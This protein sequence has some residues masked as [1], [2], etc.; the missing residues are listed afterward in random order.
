VQDANR[1]MEFD[2]AQTAEPSYYDVSF[3][4][5]PVWKWEVV[6][7]FFLGGI[8]AG[9]YVLARMAERFGGDTYRDVTRTGTHV[10]LAT[11]LPCAPLLI[12][13]LG[14]PKRF[15]HMLRIFKPTSPMNLGT[16]TMTSFVGMVMAN[17]L[18]EWAKD[19][20]LARR[21]PV[22]TVIDETVML[23]IDAAGVPLGIMLAG[24]T[25]VLLSCTANPLWAQ[26]PWIGPLFSASA[27]STGAAAINL[28]HAISD[29]EIDTPSSRALDKVDTTAHVIEA[30]A[31][32]GFLRHAG[33]QARPLRHGGLKKHMAI[34]GCAIVAS[35][36]LKRLPLD[37]EAKRAAS[38]GAAVC[39]L[40]TGFLLRWSF[41]YGGHEAARDPRAAR[42]SS[43]APANRTSGRGR[44]FPH[45]PPR[46]RQVEPQTA[47]GLR[48]SSPA[49]PRT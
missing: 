44:K 15:H 28:L 16:W 35:E 5:P 31:L 42:S 30:V 27:I 2:A 45:P 17:S 36:V 3:L 23:T 19:R 18:R 20:G 33:A 41:V 34:A 46:R 29:D 25:G 22:S 49:S 13:D 24:Y 37:G 14:D 38:I 4:K 26:N 11:A 47:T 39:G 1:R 43:R 7:Y 32:G 21:G 48:F 8:S 6:G 10:S 40:A 9:A 12:K